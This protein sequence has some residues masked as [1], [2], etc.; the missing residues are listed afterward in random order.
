MN[1]FLLQTQ[2][3]LSICMETTAGK[4]NYSGGL[5][6]L[7]GD[8]TRAMYRLGASFIAMTPIYK[9]GYV[10]QYLTDHGVDDCYPEQHFEDDYHKTGIIFPVPLLGR[11]I[12]VELWQHNTMKN[13]YGLDTSLPQNGE[14]A[15]I[16]NNLY[17][18]NGFAGYDGEAQRLM[19]EVILGVG[20]VKA[21]EALGFDFTVLHLNEG[22]GVFAAVYLISE[23]MKKG[24]AFEVAWNKVKAMTVFTTHT[25]IPAGNK[26][27]PI[28]LIMNLGANCGLT[29]DQL[30]A[31]GGD[32]TGTT[33]GSTTASLQSSKMSNAVALRHQATS[34][35]LW[36]GVTRSCPITYIDNGVDIEYWQ[37]PAI[38]KAY[39]E[40]SYQGL[41]DAHKATK[42]HLI[43]EIEKRN[44]VRLSEEH[45][46]VGFARRVIEYKRADM[47]FEDIARFEWLIQKYNFQI[48][49]SG[50]THPKDFN[51][52]G[53]LMR[54]YDMSKKY[55]NNVVF[56]QNYDA[57]IARIMTQGCDVWLGNPRI[58]EEACSTSG[59]K[60]AANGVPNLSTPDGWWYRSAR[61]CVNG[62]TIG[63]S[64]S[65]D[66]Y[67]DA[68]Y[69]Y[70]VI[71]ERVMPAY[72]NKMAWAHM[73]WASIYTAEEE[74][75]IERMCY[76]Y[77]AYLYNAPYLG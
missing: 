41:L 15:Q 50:K 74:C 62:W 13:A 70:K 47:I 39:E 14:F 67:T 17:G 36:K 40:N 64:Q 35:D 55:P 68:Q 2:N 43:D 29:Y 10:S 22:H 20:S 12:D 7:Y 71:E 4:R 53:I 66:K 58:P 69:L 49:F 60:A 9:N 3:V 57:E 19:Q 24:D 65:H 21:A 31:I 76:D 23:H 32:Y 63:E 37:H 42:R 34:H 56:L 44:G 51:S 25:P 38:K 48:V 16:T 6:A 61:Y 5:G 52:K 72:Y 33:F 30:K 54:L 27:R 11:T 8:T 77:Y 28:Q 18:E 26:S 1:N 59:M 75:S 46:I 45:I 73:M